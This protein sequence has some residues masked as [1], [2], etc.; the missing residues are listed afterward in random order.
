MIFLPEKVSELLKLNPFNSN[1]SNSLGDLFKKMVRE[2]KDKGVKYNDLT[3]Q[4]QE[5][6][7]EKNLELSEDAMIGNSILSFFGNVTI[8]GNTFTY[9]MNV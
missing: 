1:V 6:V 8:V 3:E 9:T 4:M 7:K 2:R 5:Q